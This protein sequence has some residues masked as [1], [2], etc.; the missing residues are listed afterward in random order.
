MLG[1]WR[2]PLGQVLSLWVPDCGEPLESSMGGDNVGRGAH[3]RLEIIAT[4]QRWGNILIFNIDTAG[5]EHTTDPI[6]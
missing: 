3:G 2:T 6:F 5:P 4:A 1:S